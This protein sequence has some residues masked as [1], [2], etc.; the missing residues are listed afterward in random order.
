M[1]SK[2]Y[3]QIDNF[4]FEDYVDQRYGK[5][6]NYYDRASLRNQIKY[7][8]LQW[9]LIILSATTPVL[10]A[11]EGD[12]KI[13][14]NSDLKVRTLVIIISAIVA[15]LTTAL[16]T[17]DFQDL[18]IAYRSVFE[19][20]RPELYY[21][22]FKVGEYAKSDNSKAVFVKRVEAILHTEHTEWEGIS[23][24]RA[25]PAEAGQQAGEKS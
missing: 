24:D 25:Q 10:A 1:N 6:M 15:I 8:F 4:D 13:F 14:S 3:G 5:Q 22:R 16:K 11:L 19:K 7:K 12:E 18:W 23:T 17:F 9:I 2:T 21:Y 20:L